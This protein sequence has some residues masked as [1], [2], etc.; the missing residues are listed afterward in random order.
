MNS[1]TINILIGTGIVALGIMTLMLLPRL[2]VTKD[3]YEAH[4]DVLKLDFT[5]YCVSLMVWIAVGGFILGENPGEL[6]FITEHFWVMMVLAFGTPALVPLYLHVYVF[7]DSFKKGNKNTYW[8]KRLKKQ[9]YTV[10]Q[11]STDKYI[12]HID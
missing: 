2:S 8:A 4:E 12:V 1:M 5:I 7:L 3:W 10:E 9:G 6:G 11:V